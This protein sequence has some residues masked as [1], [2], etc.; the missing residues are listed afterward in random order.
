MDAYGLAPARSYPWDMAR[1]LGTPVVNAGV[2]GTMARE[3]LDPS[4]QPGITRP[5]AL[6]LPALL[7]LRP[8]LMVVGFGTNEALR[9][10]TVAQ[11][12]ADLDALLR[13][14]AAAGVPLV[15]VGTHVDC[16][17]CTTEVEPYGAAW[18]AVLE[19]LAARYHAGLILDVER[20][21]TAAQMTDFI[22]PDAAG[23]AVV[24]R[25]VEAAV[26]SRLGLP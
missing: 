12:G 9:G 24:A 22:H 15:I 1:D 5:A 2:S 16:T 13:R 7:A 4:T 17:V 18:D 10:V 23:Y 26:R 8:R 20:G 25:R 3:V 21:L 11:A 19:R 14:I 6:Q